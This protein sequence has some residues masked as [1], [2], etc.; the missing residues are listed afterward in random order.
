MAGRNVGQYA[1]PAERIFALKLPCMLGR[2][3]PARGTVETIATRD[4]IG[5]DAMLHT[6]VAVGQGRRAG[7]IM[8]RNL[9]RLPDDLQPT[10]GCG[11]DQIAGKLCLP[12]DDDMLARQRGDLDPDD[13]LAVS[14]V[15][16]FLHHAVRIEAGIHAKPMEQVG[17]HRLEHARADPAF[18][19]LA[20][21]P[22]E[23]DAIDPLGA[24]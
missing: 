19:M 3:R 18:D 16:A 9:L 17:R 24:Q 2:N 23:D 21:L 15:E 12:I 8:Q 4:E 22:F 20:R 7:H 1:Q 14:E 5:L 13:A 6:A 10:L 11:L